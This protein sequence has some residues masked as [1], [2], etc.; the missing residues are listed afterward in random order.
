VFSVVLA[1]G[2]I[3]RGSIFGMS[4]STASEPEKEEIGP[5]DLATTVYHQMGI[6]ADKELMSP[7]DRPIEIVDG[8]K[9]RKGLLA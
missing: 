7:G 3:K 6:V 9:V 8:G 5:A 4:N 1:G 2:G